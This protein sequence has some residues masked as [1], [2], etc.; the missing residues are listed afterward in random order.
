MLFGC[1]TCTAQIS[2]VET[3]PFCDMSK[4][5]TLIDMQKSC[6]HA[7]NVVNDVY[8]PY[9]VFNFKN[10]TSSG[11]PRYEA[12][13][14]IAPKTNKVHGVG[15]QCSM[16]KLFTNYYKTFWRDEVIENEFTEVVTLS[17]FDCELMIQSRRCNNIPMN[18][19]DSSSC[20]YEG[21]R[22]PNYEW[23]KSH[24]G[25]VYKCNFYKRVVTAA[26]INSNLFGVAGCTADKLYCHLHDSIVI[27]KADVIDRCA[28]D[29]LLRTDLELIEDNVLVDWKN[30]LLFKIIDT[31]SLNCAQRKNAVESNDTH[32]NS[33]SLN[34]GTLFQKTGACEL[35]DT[36]C[37]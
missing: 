2:I 9:S 18:C 31:A 20:Q 29:V 36:K 22:V 8:L 27:W 26:T 35:S 16:S 25:V 11:Y 17:P 15:W 4:T 19:V 14:I 1:G 24:T 33:V 7:K 30:H 28:F 37:V 3:L 13:N 23:L 12:M 21:V 5:P 6:H 10:G 32:G 34:N